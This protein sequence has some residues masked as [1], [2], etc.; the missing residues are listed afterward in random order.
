MIKTWTTINGKRLKIVDMDT[1]HIL[2]CIN[3]LRKNVYNTLPDY[4]VFVDFDGRPYEELE[5]NNKHFKKRIKDK[6]KAFENEIDRRA[7][8]GRNR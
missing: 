1:T 3:M 5:I 7:L 4:S 2:N 8:N 6:I